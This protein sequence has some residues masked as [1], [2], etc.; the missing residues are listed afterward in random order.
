MKYLS[1][2]MCLALLISCGGNSEKKENGA[3]PVNESEIDKLN[4][5][6]VCG[7]YTGNYP[8][9]DFKSCKATMVVNADSNCMITCTYEG[10]ETSM[11][12]KGRWRVANGI[13]QTTFD[14]THIQNFKTA[15]NKLVPLDQDGNEITNVTSFV[16]TKQ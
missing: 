10:V 16:L 7:T 2:L 1:A 9:G 14:E 5:A 4:N 15:D 6:G 3:T 8:P 12:D 11:V 13:L